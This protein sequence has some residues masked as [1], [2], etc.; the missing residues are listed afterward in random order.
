MSVPCFRARICAVSSILGD[1]YNEIRRQK[2]HSQPADAVASD[3]G[4]PAVGSN[5]LVQHRKRRGIRYV[6]VNGGLA[7]GA[8]L[9]VLLFAE[10][11]LH[12]ADWWS[13]DFDVVPI[14]RALKGNPKARLAFDPNGSPIFV[15]GFRTEVGAGFRPDP[16]EYDSQGFRVSERA[17]FGETGIKVGVFGDSYTENLQVGEEGAYPR[18]TQERLNAADAGNRWLVFNFAVG[19]TGTY[20]QGLRHRTVRETVEL[21]H[22]VLAFLAQNDVLNNLP[23]LG[24]PFTLPAPTALRFQDGRFVVV[25]TGDDPPKQRGGAM[26]WVR[27]ESYLGALVWRAK[28]TLAAKALYEP[29]GPRSGWLKVFNPPGDDLWREAWAVTEECILRM[30]A[31]AEER[32]SRFTLLLLTDAL[33][34]DHPGALD[35]TYDFAYPNTRLSRFAEEHGIACLD[36]YP[37]FMEKKQDLDPPYFSWPRDGHYS[38]VGTELV[39]EVLSKGLLEEE[40]GE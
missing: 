36:T 32:G 2:H 3:P 4:D 19:G 7:V 16:V 23:D 37:L 28:T 39:A 11:G 18:L 24:R 33:Q 6:V 20:H 22:V 14:G 5:G 21:D 27:N 35:E 30:K 26:A 34:V 13:V 8:V 9:A 29:G 12:V 31:A 40:P 1:D 15:D 38:R 17:L 25:P 10:I